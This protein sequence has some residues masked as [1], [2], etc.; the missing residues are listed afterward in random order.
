MVGDEPPASAV[1]D[2]ADDVA[3]FAS[4]RRKREREYR[5][6]RYDVQTLDVDAPA[7]DWYA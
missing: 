2:V 3:V 5:K 1:P 7:A 4:L 6:E